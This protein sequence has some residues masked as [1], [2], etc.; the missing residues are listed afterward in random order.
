[1]KYIRG[2]ILGLILALIFGGIAY[3]VV[4][5]GFIYLFGWMVNAVDVALLGAN[6]SNYYTVVNDTVYQNI[7]AALVFLLTSAGTFCAAV[8]GLILGFGLGS[9]E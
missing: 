4:L 6:A 8:G 5:Y 3:A 1:M 9:G 2:I 7:V